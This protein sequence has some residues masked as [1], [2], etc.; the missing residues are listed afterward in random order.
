MA[1]H[2]VPSVV[3]GTVDSVLVSDVLLFPSNLLNWI[4]NAIIIRYDEFLLIIDATTKS[5]TFWDVL[6]LELYAQYEGA[7][8]ESCHVAELMD[9]YPTFYLVHH[10]MIILV[11]KC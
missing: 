10:T 3:N 9:A 1:D 11:L 8:V 5:K 7:S 6:S 2:Q 4:L